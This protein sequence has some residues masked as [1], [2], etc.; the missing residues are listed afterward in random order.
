MSFPI[1]KSNGF[2][3]FKDFLLTIFFSLIS[4]ASAKRKDKSNKIVFLFIDFRGTR[5]TQRQIIFTCFQ[6]VLRMFQQKISK[7][8][9]M[10]DKPFKPV[11]EMNKILSKRKCFLTD[12]NFR[13]S[14]LRIPLIS[15]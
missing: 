11:P 9:K 5:E 13:I 10:C 2:E 6:K 3:S 8:M 7:D 12:F 4:T 14:F 15:V 1:Y